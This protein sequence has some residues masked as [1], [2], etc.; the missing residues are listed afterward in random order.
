VPNRNRSRKRYCFVVC[1]LLIALDSLSQTAIGTA[2]DTA[3]RASKT[4]SSLPVAS[5]TSSPSR[6]E[7]AKATSSPQKNVEPSATPKKVLFRLVVIDDFSY[8]AFLAV[9]LFFH[10]LSWRFITQAAKKS[11]KPSPSPVASLAE[12]SAGSASIAALAH[13]AVSSMLPPAASAVKVPIRLRCKVA[14]D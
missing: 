1:R 5:K 4:Q 11:A 9:L 6:N 7:A 3:S 13:T 14:S 10:T 8:L 2:A 12:A